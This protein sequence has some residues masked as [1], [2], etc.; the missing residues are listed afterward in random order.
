MV[1]IAR[2]RPIYLPSRVLSVGQNPVAEASSALAIQTGRQGKL[3]GA[4]CSTVSVM[5]NVPF[6]AEA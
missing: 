5:Q 6:C 4:S 3:V 1:N 2:S